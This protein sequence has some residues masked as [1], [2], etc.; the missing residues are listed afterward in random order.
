MVY[1]VYSTEQIGIFIL[2]ASDKQNISIS[3][4]RQCNYLT[5]SRQAIV[6][7]PWSSTMQ[8][9]RRCDNVSWRSEIEIEAGAILVSLLHRAAALR[10]RRIVVSDR[11]L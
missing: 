10:C 5:L 2:T 9:S 11:V 1:Q 8:A 7:V 4:S 6:L 3:T